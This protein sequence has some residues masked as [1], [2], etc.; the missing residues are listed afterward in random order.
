M[1]AVPAAIQRGTLKRVDEAFKGFF[2]RVK[3][4][5]ETPGY[6]ALS[7]A[8]GGSTAS[9]IVSGVKLEAGRLRLPGFGWMARSAAGAATRIRTGCRSRRC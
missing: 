1:A 8:G 6:P 2:R 5:E 3:A 4:R 9:P 7:G